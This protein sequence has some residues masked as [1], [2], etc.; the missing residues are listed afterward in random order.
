MLLPLGGGIVEKVSVIPAKSVPAGP[1]PG[2]TPRSGR[3]RPGSVVFVVAVVFWIF[4]ALLAAQA[5]LGNLSQNWRWVDY[6]AASGLP[7]GR[8]QDI[9]EVDSVA[10]VLTDE[11]AAYYDGFLWTAVDTTNGLPPGRITAM[12]AGA[13]SELLVVAG[14]RLYSGNRRGFHPVPLPP[15]LD[16]WTIV[17][18]FPVDAQSLLLSL[19][20][21]GT[22]A[23]RVVR[24]EADTVEPVDPPD[25]VD[26]RGAA[27]WRTRSGRIWAQ[28]RGGLSL[29]EVDGWHLFYPVPRDPVRWVGEVHDDG[30]G[31]GVAVINGS[32]SANE[33]VV[34]SPGQEPQP[35]AQ[36]SRDMV[37]SADVLSDSTTVVVYETG[38]VRIRDGDVWRPVDVPRSRGEGVYFVRETR[39]GDL[40]FASTSAVHRFR[41]SLHRWTV[42]RHP[43]PDPRNRIND[44]LLARDSSMWLATSGG[45]GHH[46]PGLPVQ[47]TRT[48]GGVRNPIITGLA[49]DP[50]GDVWVSS[51]HS[52]TGAYRWD[53]QEWR[54]Y[55]PADG[56]GGGRIHRIYACGGSLWFAALG[57]SDFIHGSPANGGVYEYSRGHFRVWRNP[58]GTLARGTHAVAC[59]RDGSLWFGDRSGLTRWKS[60]EW[61][62]FGAA[63][64]VG[65]GSE[66]DVFA[67]AVDSTGRVWFGHGPL[68]AGLGTV[69]PDGTVRYVAMPAAGI[70][71]HVW[72]FH[73]DGDVLWV[74]TNAGVGRLEHGVWAWF[75]SRVGLAT[76]TVWPI[77]SNGS[78][79]LLGTEGGGLAI[80]RRDEERDPPPRIRAVNPL[81]QGQ[82]ARLSWR[83]TAYEGTLP[84]ADVLTRSRLDG[85][86]WS[87]WTRDRSLLLTNL[88]SGRHAVHIQAKGL[89]GQFDPG[90]TVVRFTVPAPLFLRPAFALPMAALLLALLT[91]GVLYA[92]HRRQ[93]EVVLRESEARLRAMVENAP[94]AIAIYDAETDRFVDAN[95]N[96]TRLFERERFEIVGA[97]LA[98]LL[99]PGSW[100]DARTTSDALGALAHASLRGAVRR[101]WTVHLASGEDVPCEVYVVPLVGG[102]GR[103]FRVSLFDI[104]ERREAEQ[105]HDELEARLRQSQKLEA[106]GQL[107]G[108]VA[109]DFNNLLTVIQG[110]LELLLEG[111]SAEGETAMLAGEA[112]QAALRGS[113]LTQRLLAFSRKQ[114]LAPRV[115][116]PAKVVEG[117][118]PLLRS[119]IPETIHIVTDCPPE[120]WSIRVDPH[121]LEA[122]ILNLSINARDAMPAGG[123]LTI[124]ARNV[125]GDDPSL[126]PGLTGS[127][128]V[129][130]E[131]DDTGMGMSPETVERAVD[132]FFTT[133]DVGKGSG[134]GLSMAYGFARQSGGELTLDSTLG[135]GTVVRMYF[136]R[137]TG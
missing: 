135:S 8:V 59:G 11:A 99:S 56:L 121:Q 24:V 94:E 34:W 23:Q 48:L 78:E 107:T 87:S 100:E 27:M 61:S 85:G 73:V 64:G 26:R 36:E 1:I 49:E 22:Q 109:H 10:W 115:V 42:I 86:A 137:W 110:N 68:V 47:W 75:D 118:R 67:L 114:T 4:P 116:H 71:P 46:R 97:K 104:R 124:R 122:A 50:Q 62:Q 30:T 58:D 105:R 89:F 57:D 83:A 18:A 37:M 15:S 80:L 5:P 88:S 21:P 17:R 79:I 66:S 103:L 123:T 63:Q 127:Q 14:G 77:R 25:P 108:G 31:R 132:P 70:E 72:G 33:L 54:H 44:I 81:V 84:S 92:R 16:G 117:M 133:K 130:I 41:R 69:D 101:E 95:S 39:D 134:L 113:M 128:W 12:A 65:H 20:R 32:F 9:V 96:A 7:P 13:Q 111:A 51:G 125:D 38:D 91:L 93:D 35:V 90:G 120:C 52:F 126:P 55:G 60:G 53:G 74:G 6:D 112:R 106:V 19:W 98:P 43:F 119:T 2:L 40:W 28:T 129:A 3:V 136:P 102:K 131:V 82:V 76:A 45:V 29:L